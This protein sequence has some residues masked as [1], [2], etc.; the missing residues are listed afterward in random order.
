MGQLKGPTPL[1]PTAP[2]NLRAQV[3]LFFKVLEKSFHRGKSQKHYEQEYENFDKL[4]SF[5]THSRD[6]RPSGY[7]SQPKLRDAYLKYYLPQH[8]PEAF[9][10]LNNLQNRN[11]LFLDLAKTWKSVFDFGSGPGTASISVLFW[12][13][14]NQLQGI[15]EWSL[16]DSSEG[17]I[18]LGKDFLKSLNQNIPTQGYRLNLKANLQTQ[19]RVSGIRE[20]S[21][22]VIL[23]HVFN[24]MGNGPRHRDQ[25]WEIIEQM[26]GLCFSQNKKATFII[27]EPPLREPTMD[28][29]WIRDRFSELEFAK[30]WAPCPSSTHRCPMAL[31]KAGWCYTQAPRDFLHSTGLTQFDRSVESFKREP[32]EYLSF[33]YLVVTVDPENSTNKTQ[34]PVLNWTQ[35]TDSSRNPGQ[36]CDGTKIKKRSIDVGSPHFHRGASIAVKKG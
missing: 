22:L 27:I 7:M 13:I 20:F 14:K 9:W 24:E 35:I 19:L 26:L 21:D 18:Q 36:Y 25:K 10:L 23:S 30:I 16:F 5:L 3:D 8:L 33:S 11:S 32:L 34:E 2:E 17:I 15:Q 6:K 4:R 29:M 31:A 1:S 28:L 12:M